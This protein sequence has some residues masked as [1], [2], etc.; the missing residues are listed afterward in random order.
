MAV[1]LA[2][3]P[4]DVPAAPAHAPSPLPAPPLPCIPPTPL[5]AAFKALGRLMLRVGL[6][7]MAHCDRYC[8]AKAGYPPRLAEVLRQSPCPK[9]GWVGGC[10]G[11]EP[12]MSR[13]LPSL[14]APCLTSRTHPT[15]PHPG[16]LLHYFA[17]GPADSSDADDG[18]NWC[19]W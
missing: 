14:W 2:G 15:S 17:P 5:Q 4:C 12:T 11:W 6:L 18:A 3:G 8:A 13:R 9:G 16:R 1:Q 19:G 10:A 7:L